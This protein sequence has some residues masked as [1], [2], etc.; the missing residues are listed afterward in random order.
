MT[1]K[2][3]TNM[4]C[5]TTVGSM[6]QQG[7]ASNGTVKVPYPYSVVKSRTG[8]GNP[9]WKVNIAAGV[10]AATAFTAYDQVI[11]YVAPEWTIKIRHAPS[12]GSGWNPATAKWYSEFWVRNGTGYL[13]PVLNSWTHLPLSDLQQKAKAQ[14]T[15]KL[16][17]KV[18]SLH[19]QFEGGTFVGE[20]RQTISML[21]KPASGLRRGMLEYSRR[22]RALRA[23]RKLP[24]H[25][26]QR[27][28]ADL[29]LEAVFGW[30]PLL[31]DI[32][33]SLLAY[34]RLM[35]DVRPTRFRI[36]GHETV[37]TDL[38]GGTVTDDGV[39]RW[40]IN[41]STEALCEHIYYGA[42]KP[43]AVN[44]RGDPTMQ[45]ILELSG[46]TLRDFIPTLW[47]LM[48]WSFVADYFFN[49]GSMLAAA[50][51]DTSEVAWLN[52]VTKISS[53]RMKRADPDFGYTLIAFPATDVRYK[54]LQQTGHSGLFEY[55]YRTIVRTPN[56]AM[57]IMT[58]Q[59]RVPDLW[60]KQTLNLAA[61]FLGARFWA[62]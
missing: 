50:A 29:Y 33:D 44:N 27:I 53:T 22:A 13:M 35:D 32:K 56:V 4:L 3:I 45:R 10:N 52:Q 7:G 24:K 47:E 61:L 12:D 15:R 18:R 19:H 25:V 8:I 26:L 42:F 46:F 38:G 23:G 11:N 21:C 49:I 54:E 14:A 51:T 60:S 34:K 20:I 39:M 17:A 9:R 59:F 62:R 55:S 30:Q 48:P 43:S 57:P 41:S 6:F 28:I 1:V 37:S 5:F 40:R 2:T 16:Y 58:P 31:A 36:K